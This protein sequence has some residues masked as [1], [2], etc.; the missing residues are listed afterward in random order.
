MAN[1]NRARRIAAG[2]IA[3]LTHLKSFPALP[4]PRRARSTNSADVDAKLP[5][6][7]RGDVAMRRSI[8]DYHSFLDR[9]VSRL[10][11]DNAETREHCTDGHEQRLRSSSRNGILH[12]QTWKSLKSGSSSTSQFATSN[13]RVPLMSPKICLQG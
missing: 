8:G 9:A 4:P 10:D 5:C 6:G 1:I 7:K 3:F 12:R 11:K 2:H 13:G